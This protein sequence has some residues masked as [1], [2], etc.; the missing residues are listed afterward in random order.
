MKGYSTKTFGE[1][2]GIQESDN[3]YEMSVFILLRR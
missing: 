3:C 1:K 2:H